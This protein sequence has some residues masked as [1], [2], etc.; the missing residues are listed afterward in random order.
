MKRPTAVVVAAALVAVLVLV[1]RGGEDPYTIKLRLSNAQGLSN[2][3]AVAVGGIEVGSTKLRSFQDHVEITLNIKRKYAPIDRSATATIIARNAIGQKEVLL[4]ARRPGAAGAPDGFTLPGKQVDAATDLDQ[5][6]GT[7]DP[8]TRTRLAVLLNESGLAFDGRKVD[9][10]DLL[11]DFAPALSAG[12][13]FLGELATGSTTLEKLL[14]TSDSYIGT[15]ADDRRVLTGMVDRLGRTTETVADR[16]A[17]LRRALAEAPSALRSARAFLAELRRTT[18]PLA[19]TARL[20]RRT[21]PPLLKTVNT[22]EPF[23]AAAAPT[24][25]AATKAA[26]SVSAL[27]TRTRA[28]LRRAVPALDS[29]KAMSQNELAPVGTTLDRSMDNLLATVD[30]W[31]HAIQFSDG[32]S[33]VFRGEASIAPSLYE[34]YL[35]SLGIPSAPVKKREE[36]ASGKTPAAPAAVARPT[37]PTTLTPAAPKPGL[38]VPRLP[39]LPKVPTLPN[40]TDV[41]K[42]ILGG[43]T[44]TGKTTGPSA[45]PNS[46]GQFLDYLLGQ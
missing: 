38:D 28:S 2:G 46:A 18:T 37:S 5:L 20:L 23:R 14:T 9:F 16:R 26:P 19:S 45:Q 33:H 43:V 35:N 17:A 22:L 39:K 10:E 31:A 41:L 25:D 3:S 44:G 13:D 11:T 8:D 36:A 1:F 24:L 40:A 21:A 42:D 6:L 34:N 12:S 32:L 27:A 15:L 29:I 30:N 7:L 4:T